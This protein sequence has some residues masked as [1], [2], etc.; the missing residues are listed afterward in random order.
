MNIKNISLALLTGVVILSAT[1]CLK[2]DSEALRADEK[3][4]LA[5]YITTN[6]ITVAPTAS[7][8][9]YIE[10]LAGTGDS[11]RVDNWM[12]MRY[13]ARLVSNNAVVMTSDLQTAKDNNIDA[14]G[15][16]YGPT[17]LI[18]G[19]IRP[20]GLNEGISKM[21]EGGK[22]RLIFSSDIG[23][24]AQST[25]NIPAYSSLI[26]DI[27]LIKVIPDIKAY[28]NSLV[29]AYLV[30]N[31]MAADSTADG[32]Y[33]K[34]TKVGTGDLPT[35]GKTV[36]VTYSGKFLNGQVFDSSGKSFN[37]TIGANSVI[38][39]FEAAVKLIK[40]GGSGTVVIPYN[41]AYGIYGRYDN[42]GRIVIPP[43]KSLVFD[44]SVASIAK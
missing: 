34:E 19:Q 27:E 37:V 43:Y 9:Y 31:E 22:A 39:G 21:K 33:F 6:N 17:R 1:S 11:I 13:T 5:E 35:A 3:K 23:L 32:I 14:V 8:L 24:G 42:Y 28:E 38:P 10:T 36:T 40:K 15:I 25:G 41:N 7:G 30:T 18:L 12:E 26:F 2:D 16:Y 4:I 20:I 44:I 29:Q